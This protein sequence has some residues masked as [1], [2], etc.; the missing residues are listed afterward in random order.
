MGEDAE[1][2]DPPS[3]FIGARMSYKICYVKFPGAK[4]WRTGI[5]G[6]INS[7]TYCWL[8]AYAGLL[9]WAELT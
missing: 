4:L 9:T 3:L 7:L 8:L 5:C 1:G 6:W 2:S